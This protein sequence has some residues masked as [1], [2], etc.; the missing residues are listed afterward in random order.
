MT[1]ELVQPQRPQA[2]GFTL[3]EVLIALAVLA[4][5]ISAAIALFAAATA[6][7]K[8]AINLTN[9]SAIAEQAIADIESVLL[10]G[11]DP[12]TLSESNPLESI[13]KNYP[14]YRLEAKFYSLPE[15]PDQAVVEII[16]HW[17]ARGEPRQETFRQ[18]VTRE[19][20]I[21]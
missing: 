19:A 21:R 3:I 6:A 5:G 13:E 7:H 1:S 14:G 16:V 20:L 17:T 8:R 12:T 2:S 18:L 10:S 11:V 4:L 15:G 9:A